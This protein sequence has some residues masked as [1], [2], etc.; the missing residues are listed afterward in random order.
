MKKFILI[1]AIIISGCKK[2]DRQ[3]LT[4]IKVVESITG[5]PVSGANLTLLRCK[6]G[7]PFGATVLS[8]GI[9]DN[10]GICQVPTEHYIDATSLNVL[11][12]KYWPFAVEK[13]TTVSMTAEGWIQL[14]IHRTGTYPTGSKLLLTI[15]GQ[16]AS[17]TDITEYNTAAD[18]LLQVKGFGSQQNK[19][20][21]QVVD[22]SFN[23]LNNGTINE[24]QVP[25]FD[26]LKSLTLNY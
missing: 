14:R 10:N 26:T 16:S 2:E 13:N 18:S 21:W 5:L 11:T 3:N 9:S 1:L 20:D 7:C 15:H 6:Y 12:T 8:K 4:T 19:M 23:L 24:L 22:A 17:M 25:R